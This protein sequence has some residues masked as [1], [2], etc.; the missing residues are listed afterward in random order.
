MMV[1]APEPDW[2]FPKAELNTFRSGLKGDLILP[3]DAAYAAARAVWNGM[4]DRRPALI[5]RCAGVKDVIAGISFARRMGL[6]LAV[7]SGGHNI[8]G[9][10]TCDGGLV[11]DLSLLK[12]I[13]VDPPGRR[14]RAGAGVLWG[15]L[16][17][18]TQAHGLAA[19]GGTVSLTGIAGL[20]L[21]GGY[22]WLRNK[23]GLSCD[24]LAAA[25]V[26]TADGRVVR[27]CDD[28]NPDLLWG[29][30]GGGGNFGVVTSF[31][32]H[33]H[34]VGPQVM[35]V[36]VFHDGRGERLKTAIRFYRDF[37]AAAPDE[38][39]ALGLAGVFPPGAHQ[40]PETVQGLPYFAI[41]ALYA[42]A[43]AVGERILQP[44]R[45]FQPPL[46][47]FS[48]VRPYVEAQKAFDADYPEGW[49]YYWKSA[50]LLRL[51]DEV[52][53]RVIPHIRRQPSPYSTTG[54][55]A[56]GG[57]MRREPPGG[58]AFH[59]RQA[60]FLLNPE[61]N[62][63]SPGD[64]SANLRWVREFATAMQPYSDGSR[65]LNFAGFQE[66]GQTMMRAGFGPHYARLAALKTKWDPEN[67]FRLNQNI[68]PA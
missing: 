60:S 21:G 57:A 40:F 51:D 18:A 19:P 49:R 30:R 7:R 28:E 67:L 45:D 31:E 6:T 62:W 32:Y 56:V 20:T 27:A 4:I 38:V 64:D 23:L 68:P 58:A 15:E 50:N 53:D 54:L 34:P 39:S 65:Y 66:E 42:G 13:E 9:H 1:G 25:E 12:Q 2:P 46:V 16:D 29:L 10:G 55:W 52:I 3:T 63:E 47:D 24:N 11:L 41:C 33:L 35:F 59:G 14:A 43:A 61:A 5:V 8:A 17:V 37:I 44:L 22:G 26:V 48:G 36:F